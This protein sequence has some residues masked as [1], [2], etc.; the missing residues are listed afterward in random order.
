M[1]EQEQEQ[2]VLY[3]LLVDKRYRIVRYILLIIA[4]FLVTSNYTI[5]YGNLKLVGTLEFAIYSLTLFLTYLIPFYFNVYYLMPRCL[6]TERYLAYFISLSVLIVLMLVSQ[7]CIEDMFSKAVNIEI[8]PI[9]NTSDNVMFIIDIFGNFFLNLISFTGFS[10]TLLFRYWIADNQ[11]AGQLA[12]QHLQA[13]VEHIKQQVNPSFLFNTLNRIARIGETDSARASVKL[14]KFSK[15][16]RYQLYDSN[17]NE[18]FLTSEIQFL[19]DYLTLEQ[20]Y[21]GR[22]KYEIS[23]RGDVSCI[24]V[25]PM[26]FIPFV[27][28]L[29]DGIKDCEAHA[30]LSLLFSID[31]ENPTKLVF[32]CTGDIPTDTS[33]EQFASINQ[34][35]T[36]L[37]GNDYSLKLMPPPFIIPD[38][39]TI[40]LTLNLK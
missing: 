20:L 34:R 10:I 12:H 36:F 29:I 28:Q 18:V 16:L 33:S 24:L 11:R 3:K 35:L 23:T 25:P 4:L 15:L 17:Q 31:E 30:N 21:Y 13:Q 19:N 27:R 1:E 8:Y 40:S 9:Y 39:H 2:T 14:M 7:Y 26:L 32:T 6:L 22:L 5:P 37:Y 38:G